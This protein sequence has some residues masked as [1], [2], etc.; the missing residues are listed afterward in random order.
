L[1]RVD[2]RSKGEA[3]EAR[4]ALAAAGI[5]VFDNL[6]REYKAHRTASLLGIPISRLGL[7]RGRNAADDYRRVADEVL[8]DLDGDPAGRRD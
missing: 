7:R 4:S 5:P 2:A 1:T 3:D 6:V 8:V